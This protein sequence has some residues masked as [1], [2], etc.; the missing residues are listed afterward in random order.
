M[1]CEGCG[2]EYW[3][4]RVLDKGAAGDP[5]TFQCSTCEQKVKAVPVFAPYGTVEDHMVGDKKCPASGKPICGDCGQ[6]EVA[7]K[8]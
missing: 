8:R 6:L 4:D 2:R 5:R 3:A 1:T 7:Q